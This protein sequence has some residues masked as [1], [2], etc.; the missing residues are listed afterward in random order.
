MLAAVRRLSSPGSLDRNQIIEKPEALSSWSPQQPIRCRRSGPSGEHSQAQTAR[1]RGA[2]LRA[3]EG[4][5]GGG[6]VR[7]GVSTDSP[8]DWATV[9]V[10]E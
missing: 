4:R 2:G 9:S 7:G 8:R 6:G 10:H 1:Q 3:S 5:A